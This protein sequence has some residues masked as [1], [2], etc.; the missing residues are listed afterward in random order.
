MPRTVSQ[1]SNPAKISRQAASA[2]S[3]PQR[4]PSSSSLG[5]ADS[6][7]TQGTRQRRSSR[8]RYKKLG[9]TTSQNHQSKEAPPSTSS[10]RPQAQSSHQSSQ[11]SAN[12]PGPSAQTP[13]FGRKHTYG[14]RFGPQAQHEPQALNDQQPG[15]QHETEDQRLDTQHETINRQ[16]GT[17]QQPGPHAAH[18]ARPVKSLPMRYLRKKAAELGVP[19]L[20]LHKTTGEIMTPKEILGSAFPL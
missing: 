19:V 10:A 9:R 7:N 2:K 4:T 12:Q 14:Q 3:H 11:Q 18:L 20:W 13:R 8:I 17:Q 6:T 15:S 16:L 1:P 5:L